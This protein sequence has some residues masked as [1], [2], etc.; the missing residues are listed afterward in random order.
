[1][2]HDF[3]VAEG[4]L[5]L[6]KMRSGVN[7]P[8]LTPEEAMDVMFEVMSNPELHKRAS[9]GYKK[10]GQSIDFHGK[11]DACVC[12]EAG[13]FWR[14]ETTDNSR[15]C[16]GEP[17]SLRRPTV[18]KLPLPQQQAKLPGPWPSPCARN[19]IARSEV[20]GPKF[21]LQNFPRAG[22]TDIAASA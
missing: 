1:M 5:L 8:A 11:E 18:R 19:L 21:T 17:K 6:E 3:G 13:I 16:A 4:R 7:V 15:T 10:V 20:C 2:R 9:E 14:E 22:S 12:R